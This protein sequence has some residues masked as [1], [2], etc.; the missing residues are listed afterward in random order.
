M[1]QQRPQ[2]REEALADVQGFI[3]PS[4]IPIEDVADE[5]CKLLERFENGTSCDED[6]DIIDIDT[7]IVPK[8]VDTGNGDL[9]EKE[10]TVS[11][12]DKIFRSTQDEIIAALKKD[13]SI[14]PEVDEMITDVHIRII[15]EKKANGT[16]TKPSTTF[17]EQP[18]GHTG[19]RS[20]LVPFG[21]PAP[22]VPNFDAAFSVLPL[23]IAATVLYH[24]IRTQWNLTRVRSC[25]QTWYQLIRILRAA[26]VH[27]AFKRIDRNLRLSLSVT[28][29][30]DRLELWAVSNKNYLD[31]RGVASLN[32]GLQNARTI[33]YTSRLCAVLMDPAGGSVAC[34]FCGVNSPN[35]NQHVHTELRIIVKL[36]FQRQYK[37]V[38]PIVLWD[39][40]TPEAK[41]VFAAFKWWVYQWKREVV[42]IGPRRISNLVTNTIGLAHG[43]RAGTVG[44]ILARWRRQRT[45]TDV[46]FNMNQINIDLRWD[47]F[48]NSND[49]YMG[50][51]VVGPGRRGRTVSYRRIDLWPGQDALERIIDDELVQVLGTVPSMAVNQDRMGIRG[52]TLETPYAN[53]R[54]TILPA[55][56]LPPHNA[57]WGYA[58]RTEE[59][60]HH[61]YSNY[62]LD[63]NAGSSLAG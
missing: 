49:I 54:T 40:R 53:L 26:D 30:M 31:A 9:E 24:F 19:L 48:R 4:I 6:D 59:K 10:C 47:A 7:D 43:S 12:I 34:P 18:L 8:L 51:P 28:S 3:N 32:Q 14:N 60:W 63:P 5:Y 27:A 15:N 42:R 21:V 22:L 13:E 1:D 20:G 58:Y 35:V 61:F 55:A 29:P 52:R 16:D 46:W 50:F 25:G 62:P 37:F 56:E 44:K 36:F 11:E 41:A 57:T 23:D 17:I 2:T 38:E 33:I 45:G 39:A